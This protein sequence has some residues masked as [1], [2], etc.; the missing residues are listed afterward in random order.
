MADQP[1]II[2]RIKKGGHAHHGGAWKL[3]YADFVTAMMAF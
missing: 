3:A 2:K 1:I